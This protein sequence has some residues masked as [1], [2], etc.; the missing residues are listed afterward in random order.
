[1]LCQKMGERESRVTVT[2]LVLRVEIS[3]NPDLKNAQSFL[4]GSLHES[5]QLFVDDF[6]D[7]RHQKRIQRNP[8]VEIRP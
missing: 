4:A 8:G 2:P 5:R 6:T 1:M 3:Q 7:G